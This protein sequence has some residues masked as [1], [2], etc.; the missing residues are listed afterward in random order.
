MALPESIS[1]IDFN[2]NFGGRAGPFQS[3]GSTY[4]VAKDSTNVYQLNILKNTNPGT[5]SWT[6]E[7][8]DTVI[9]T[10]TV[11]HSIDAVQV[12]TDIY[13]GVG[14]DNGSNVDYRFYIFSMSSDSFTTTDEVIFQVTSR[15]PAAADIMIN[16]AVRSDGSVVAII[17]DDGANEMG[18]KSRVSY[19]VR[20]TGGTWDSSTTAVDDGGAVNYNFGRATLDLNNNLAHITYF[21]GTDIQHKSLSSGGSLS[22][23]EAVNDTTTTD[24]QSMLA[25]INDGSA[26]IIE[27]IWRKSSNSHGYSSLITDD[28]TPAA[29]AV[30]S[31]SVN[32]GAEEFQIYGDNTNDKFYAVYS[33]NADGDLYLNEYDGSWGTETEIH[34]AIGINEVAGIGAFTNDASAFVLAWFAEDQTGGLNEYYDEHVLAAGGLNVNLTFISSTSILYAVT[35]ISEITPGFVTSTTALFAPTIGIE[36]LPGF[37]VSTS[38]L[39]APTISQTINLTFISSISTL[40]PPAV[41]VEPQ[42]NLTFISSSSILY[43]PS[44]E[45]TIILG[46]ISSGTTVYAQSAVAVLSVSL[47]FIASSSV[48]YSLTISQTINTLGFIGS[49]SA[50]Y[51]PSTQSTATPGFITS[52]TTVYSLSASVVLSI[53][54]GFISSSS[55]VYS[56]TISQTINLTFIAS[57]SVVYALVAGT[58]Q[59]VN[60][61]FISSSTTVYA[62]VITQTLTLGFISTASTLYAPVVTST[63]ALGFISSSSVVYA[64]TI[65]QTLT[66]G[67]VSSISTLYSPSPES[68]VV[69]GLIDSSTVVYSLTANN[70]AGTQ[71][72]NLT[73][74]SSSS[75][76]YSPSTEST[77]TLGFISSGTVVY[78]QSAIVVLNVSLG[79]INSASTLYSLSPES[80]IALGFITSASII[81]T[82]SA[83]AEPQVNLGFIASS[84][85]LYSPSAE[86][87]ITLGLITSTSALYGPALE[88]TIELGFI[89]STSVVYA[90]V[91]TLGGALEVFL[92]F[93]P[94]ATIVYT[95]AVH[96]KPPYEIVITQYH[97]REVVIDQ[98]YEREVVIEEHYEHEVIIDRDFT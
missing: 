31:D 98:Y 54:L 79:F 80:T 78:A 81:Y 4:G 84:S 88:S 90:P 10:G 16:I 87:T 48:L 46:F 2:I 14:V 26:N 11:I 6:E 82:L 41:A 29:E 63:I 97:E 13:I 94:S 3:G 17:Q 51:N 93:I 91:I 45:S 7:A 28:G 12:G 20:S 25:W 74:I 95:I 57:T 39:Y 52:V 35:E 61:G 24:G 67:F 71:T 59:T 5:D 40:Y 33:H 38:T 60:L 85:A 36:V 72:V 66:L 15:I 55:T 43:N 8:T 47:G 42:V 44:P 1:G 75:I 27:A 83:L 37:V 68:T 49:G 22:S 53:N 34:D 96:F 65:E 69:L 56:P 50:L 21:D 58:P 70:A 32:I 77:I 19:L 64:P 76:L 89:G 92:A 62:L 86:S 73:F 30:F 23:A 9:S 18:T